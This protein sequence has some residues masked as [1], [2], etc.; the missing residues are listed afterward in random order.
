MEGYE[1]VLQ[2][3]L[4]NGRVWFM[5]KDGNGLV[6]HQ[7][8]NN[9][10]VQ[11]QHYYPFG[12]QMQGVRDD[13]ISIS[14]ENRFTYNEKEFEED[15]GLHN[16]GARF[17]DPAI[18]RFTTVDALAD[19]PNQV[20][21]STYAYAW[22][23]PIALTDPDGNCPQC[24]VGF[25]IGFIAEVGAQMIF[26]GKSLGDVDY[27]SAVISGAVGM[28]TG[29]VASV[30]KS[31]AKGA[32]KKEVQ[33]AANTA[34]E[35]T[36]SVGK[37]VVSGNDI[38]LTQTVSD[39]AMSKVGGQVKVV[40]DANIKVK[41]KGLDR[42]SRI[43]A[44][45]PKSTGRAQNVKKAQSSLNSANNMNTTANSVTGN[46]LQI[47]SDNLRSTFRVNGSG[48]V[49]NGGQMVRDNTRVDKPL[50]LNLKEQQ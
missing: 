5:D 48:G 44:N 12:M 14:L 38:S 15:W 26:E 18:G 33:M 30:M 17:Y 34:L 7:Q 42:V 32:I 11:T 43:S 24:P 13:V 27:K 28:A 2:D 36:E 23:N 31:M 6:N 37:Q 21:K 46:T 49:G 22:N 41:E 3:H 16:Y 19:H 47:A 10:V 1:Y 8:E 45:D 9:D 50:N 4:G 20:D 40:S 39:V 29:G 35:V 25:A